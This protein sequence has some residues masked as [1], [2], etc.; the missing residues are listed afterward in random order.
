MIFFH[1][2]DISNIT[3]KI[4][5]VGQNDEPNQMCYNVGKTSSIY[6][7]KLGDLTVTGEIIDPLEGEANNFKFTEEGGSIP[8]H[9]KVEVLIHVVTSI[10]PVKCTIV[11]YV[12]EQ[13]YYFQF[14]VFMLNPDSNY[15]MFIFVIENEEN[16]VLQSSIDE[17]TFVE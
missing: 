16:Y 8:H 4:R 13:Y 17:R 6:E 2:T 9:E 14:L 15:P 5:K 12:Q 10:P 3:A 1:L 11:N 7:E